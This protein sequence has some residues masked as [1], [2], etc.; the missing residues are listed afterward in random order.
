[1]FEEK[2]RKAEGAGPLFTAASPSK[3]RARGPRP[4]GRLPS[5]LFLGAV[6]LLVVN[7]VAG[8]QRFIMARAATDEAD[9]LAEGDDDDD[10]DITAVMLSQADGERVAADA[11]ANK[12]ARVR[13]FKRD[14]ATRRISLKVTPGQSIHVNGRGKWGV[15]LN[16]RPDSDDWQLFIVKTEN[17]DDAHF[18]RFDDADAYYAACRDAV[19]TDTL[20]KRDAHYVA[21]DATDG[22]LEPSCATPLNGQPVAD[23]EAAATIASCACPRGPS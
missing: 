1:M 9:P 8:Q 4:D 6:A 3:T 18:M 22:A 16:A 5:P 14:I 20:P 11:R 7:S 19:F 12:R 21:Y 13:V 15:F 23:F 10:V 2:A 17:D